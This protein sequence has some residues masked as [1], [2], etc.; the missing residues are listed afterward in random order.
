M[1]QIHTVSK[2]EVEI[3]D[4]FYEMTYNPE[5]EWFEYTYVG[6]EEGEYGYCYHVTYADG[7]TKTYLDPYNKKEK[8]GKSIITYTKLH[9]EVEAGAMPYAIDY[10]PNSVITLKVEGETD[11][12]ECIEIDLTSVGGRVVEVDPTLMALTIGVDQEVTPGVK[13]LPITLKDAMNNVYKSQ[14]EIEVKGRNV[15]ATDDFDWDEATIYFMQWARM[16]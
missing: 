12:L 15:T 13:V 6:L 1:G 5:E 11:Q 3:N 2:V 7:T 8:D 10:N 16:D 9:F 14:V 4:Q